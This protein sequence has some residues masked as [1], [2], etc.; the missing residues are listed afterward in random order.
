MILWFYHVFSTSLGGN[1]PLRSRQIGK[2]IQPSEG[3]LNGSLERM[4]G[5]WKSTIHW[6]AGG[7]ANLITSQRGGCFFSQKI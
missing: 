2:S 4:G 3:H 6:K 5:H 7:M 1:L